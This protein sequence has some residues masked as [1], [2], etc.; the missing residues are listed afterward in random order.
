MI[1]DSNL[2]KSPIMHNTVLFDLDGTLIDQFIA[3]HK[4]VNH[5]QR[6]LQ[7]QESSFIEVK[8]AVGGSIRLTLERLFDNRSLDETLPLFKEHFESI[9]MDDV[10][11][12]PGVTDF[13]SQLKASSVKMGILTNKIG[14][15]ARATVDYLN[16]KDF[17]LSVLGAEDIGLKKPDRKFTQHILNQM[18]VTKDEACLIGD[19]PFDYQTGVEAGIPVYLVATGTHS[20]DALR[21]ETN[22]ANIYRDIASLASAVF[23]Y[24]LKI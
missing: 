8:C 1:T 19:S 7:L 3:I 11:V 23:N 24:H 14:T 18:D 4:S 15:H 12:L 6:E 2:A 17:F 20:I 22:C 16:I 9:M 13:L 10:F 5:V 21:A